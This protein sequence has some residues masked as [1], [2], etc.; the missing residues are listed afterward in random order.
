MTVSSPD[1]LPAY[2]IGQDL[3]S[4]SIEDMRS[5][6]DSLDREILRLNA[7]IEKKR[8]GRQAAESIFNK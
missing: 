5:W 1:T 7:E 4:A 6:V 3:Y 8:I 2:I